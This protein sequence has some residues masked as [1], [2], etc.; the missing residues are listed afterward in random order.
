[1][2]TK[3]KPVV[4]PTPFQVGD[5]VRHKASGGCYLILRTPVVN[6]VLEYNRETYYK[7]EAIEDGVI[8]CRC[9]SEMEDGRFEFVF[10]HTN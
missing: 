10:H 5:V 1:M 9:I 4:D 3:K 8:S 7:Y 6:D 2:T